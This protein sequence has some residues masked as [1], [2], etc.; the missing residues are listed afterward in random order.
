MTGNRVKVSKYSI[1]S[2]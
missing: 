1:L 2:G